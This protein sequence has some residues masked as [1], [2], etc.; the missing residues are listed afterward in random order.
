MPRK[1]DGSSL[2]KYTARVWFGHKNGSS[3]GETADVVVDASTL[4]GAAGR[5]ARVARKSVKGRFDSM[6]V[7]VENA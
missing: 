1:G 2:K 6:T 3:V 5:A 4:V 7:T